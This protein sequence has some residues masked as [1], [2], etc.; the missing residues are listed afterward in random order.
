MII[1]C[2]R[3]GETD[4]NLKGI[5]SGRSDEGL[6]SKGI[7][8]AQKINL[9][10]AD[11]K[12]DA[13]YVSPMRRAIETAEIIVPEY[14]YIIDERLAE[15]D[16][17]GLKDRSIDELWQNPLWNSLTEKRTLEGAETFGSG[18]MRVQDFLS[19]IK[20]QFPHHEPTILLITHSFISRCLWAIEQGVKDDLDY[21]KFHHQNDEV[22]IYKIK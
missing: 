10:I 7:A 9:E 15:R 20:K 16:L 22:I 17:A 5:V 3:H 4:S 8:Q 2:V 21:T 6:S 12:F 1:Y 11:T 19:D 14:Q 18:L 13:V